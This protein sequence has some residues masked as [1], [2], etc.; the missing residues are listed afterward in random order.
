MSSLLAA[1]FDAD[2][3]NGLTLKFAAQGFNGAA[4]TVLTL[5]GLSGKY[6]SF[7]AAAV[8]L[9]KAITD[10]LTAHELVVD[11]P[12]AQTWGY[13]YSAGTLL[14]ALRL[15]RTS[16]NIFGIKW[17]DGTLPPAW[18]GFQGGS[19]NS[20][21]GG[22]NPQTLDA[23]WQAGRLWVAPRRTWAGAR[24]RR[25]LVVSEALSGRIVSRQLGAVRDDWELRYARLEW[26]RLFRFAAEDATLASSI[27]GLNAGD[28]NFPLE[29]LW[30]LLADSANLPLRYTPAHTALGVYHELQARATEMEWL[31]ALAEATSNATEGRV[32]YDVTLPLMG[33]VP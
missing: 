18:L 32:L 17:D 24:P 30:E 27:P 22:A 23:W 29:S 6:Y 14:G 13:S 10:Q 11:A 9:A 12:N 7:T 20:A 21:G 31:E 1:P 4:T 15:T 25:T 8:N 19:D 5:S 28:P 16:S 3:L 33:W 26:A 2:E